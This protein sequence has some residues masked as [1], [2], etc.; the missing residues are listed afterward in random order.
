M[1][2]LKNTTLIGLFTLALLIASCGSKQSAAEQEAIK[3]EVE[4]LESLTQEVEESIETVKETTDSLVN[5]VDEILK[6]V[7]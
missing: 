6:D 5:E 2:T 4:Q 1:K 7:E 3:Q